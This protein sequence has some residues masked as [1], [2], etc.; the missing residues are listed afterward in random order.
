MRILETGAGGIR[1]W[2]Y[3]D[4][5]VISREEWENAGL[6]WRRIPPSFSEV[7]IGKRKK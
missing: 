6:S 4:G 5:I 7:V 2:E 1:L 3:A